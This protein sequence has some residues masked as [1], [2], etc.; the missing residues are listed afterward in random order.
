[1]IRVLA[2]IPISLYQWCIS[3]LFGTQCRFAP[4]CSHYTK[5]AIRT[6]GVA[7]GMWLGVQRILRCQ[8]FGGSGYDPVPPARP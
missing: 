3:P 6:H 2:C 8:P 1:M 4:S 5:Q 7:R